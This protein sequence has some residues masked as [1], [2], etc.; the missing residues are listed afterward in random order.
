MA[1][2]ILLADK[3]I[4]IQ[5]VVEMLFSGKD[6]EVTCVSDGETA[7]SE[8]VRVVP[9]VM[10]AD[11]D[12]PRVDG[13]GFAARVKQIPQLAQTPVIL[14]AS[15]DDVIDTAKAQK[16][17]IIDHIAKPFESQELIGKIKTAL[18]SAPPRLAEPV[19]ATPQMASP[20]PAAARPSPATAKP[21][22][23]VPSDIFGI[24]DDA[25]GHGDLP[26]SADD[27]VYV[28]E[29]EVEVE[30]PPFGEKDRALPTGA[31]AMDEIRAGLG[32]GGSSAQQAPPE[33]TNF[34]SL[35]MATSSAQ[36]Y[37]PSPAPTDFSA[38]SEPP[39]G[40]AAPPAREPAVQDEAIRGAAE[41]TVARV[42]KEV[43]EKVAW[44][45]IPELAER[46]IREEIERLKRSQ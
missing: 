37:A 24:V 3:S 42:A 45:V 46:L 36:D 27:S 1:V 5:K 26:L 13:Y 23:A 34:E 25:P 33:F 12:L 18:T 17:G 44:E 15:R 19:A 11:V 35:D 9:D 2:K 30:K 10:L 39:P 41:Q 6:Y 8:A 29:P 43:L 32:L 38:P 28:V 40:F 20:Q 14:M 22:Q 21:T 16:A 4:T 31:R 7:L